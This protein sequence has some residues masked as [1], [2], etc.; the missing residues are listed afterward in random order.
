MFYDQIGDFFEKL[1]GNIAC[2]CEKLTVQILKLKNSIARNLKPKN[3]IV[4][5]QIKQKKF[6]IFALES[7]AKIIS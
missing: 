2:F 5:T 1:L 4:H 6:M 7:N 3:C